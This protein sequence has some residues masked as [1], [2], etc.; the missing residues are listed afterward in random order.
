MIS[1]RLLMLGVWMP[2]VAGLAT[3]LTAGGA[4]AVSNL[5]VALGVAVT[6]EVARV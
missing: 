1:A 3:M 4:H 2:G 6:Y 5:V